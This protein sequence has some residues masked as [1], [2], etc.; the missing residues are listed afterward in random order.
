VAHWFSVLYF[1]VKPV[2]CINA[3][4]C[5]DTGCGCSPCWSGETCEDPVNPNPPVFDGNTV[6]AFFEAT[7]GIMAKV[8]EVSD[9]DEKICNPHESFCECAVIRY[10]LAD[11]FGGLFEINKETG[12][13]SFRPKNKKL[14]ELYELNVLAY[15][16]MGKESTTADLK[17]TAKIIDSITADETS[18]GKDPV[19][20][21]LSLRGDNSENMNREAEKRI[22]ASLLA[23]CGVSG[24]LFCIMIPSPIWGRSGDVLEP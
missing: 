1:S 5:T 2:K 10:K 8:F 22:K 6:E 17:L 7:D 21:I 16:P 20:F 24:S 12:E 23:D 9:E 4:V 13:I 14:E 18:E 19:S 3:D 15:N 11:D